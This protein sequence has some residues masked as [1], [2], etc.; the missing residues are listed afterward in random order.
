[1]SHPPQSPPRIAI[2]G[3]GFAGLGMGIRLKQAGIESFTIYEA[4]DEIG[5]TWRDNTYPG[6]ACDVQSHLYSYSFEPRPEWTRMFAPQAE[7]FDYLKHCAEKYDLL[8]HI[9]C[10]TAV[11]DARYDEST[12]GWTVTVGKG[13]VVQADMVVSATG[14]LSQPV[15]PN[16]PGIDDFEGNLFHSARWDHDYDLKGK[17]VGVIGTG[18]SAIQFVP[19]IAPDV[20][21]LHLFQRTPPWV[22]SKPDRAISERERERFRRRPFWQRLWRRALYWFLEMRVIVFVFFPKLMNVVAWEGRRF[23]RDNVPD[24]DLRKKLTPDYL[25]GCKRILMSDVYYPALT[26]PNVDVVTKG[27]QEITPDG[28][29]TADGK[30]H[31]LDALIM[32]T[33]FQ[34]AEAIP[35]FRVAGRDGLLLDEAWRDGAEAYLGT[36]V[37]GFPNLFLIVGPN[38]ALG[39]SS[40]IFMIE[41]QIQYI[42]DC[43]AA[44]QRV[45]FLSLEVKKD[46]QDKYNRMLE[47]RLRRTIWN[48]GGCASWYRTASGKNTT[49]WPGFTWAFR[50]RTRKVRL[51][52]F[53]VVEGTPVRSPA[54]EPAPV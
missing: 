18:A 39:H 29:R 6:V 37:S 3:S 45:G 25:P 13:E 40:M 10:G 36:V 42:M 20:E 21:K 7:I 43:V 46:V 52:D 12:C 1:M 47:R 16:I 30:E 22:L 51:T 24:P 48:T 17:K 33:G 2:I 32:G 11:T 41:S 27:I 34:A 54:P 9:R 15:Y 35:P 4:A 44:R 53:H 31:R 8:P 5:G 50:L 28:I 38:T 23:I 49:L 26:R 14:G 19:E